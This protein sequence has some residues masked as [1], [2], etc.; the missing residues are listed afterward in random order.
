ML[1]DKGFILKIKQ[2][3][4]VIVLRFGSDNRS[5]DFIAIISEITEYAEDPVTFELIPVYED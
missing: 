3:D 4:N 2:N 5:D 1:Y